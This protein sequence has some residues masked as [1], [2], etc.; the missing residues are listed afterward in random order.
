ML[1]KLVIAI[2]GPAA[3]GKSTTSKLVAER[4][5][6][7]YIDTGA[8]YRA[9]TWK[10][11]RN[12]IDLEE[13]DII[14]ELAERTSVRLE[15]A[16]DEIKVFLDGEDVSKEIRTQEVT[17]AVSAV[18]AIEKVRTVMVREQRKIGECGGVVVD[19]RDIGTVVFPNADVKIFMIADVEERARRRQ[20]ELER[21]GATVDLSKL[22]E[23]IVTRDKKDSGRNISPLRK[24]DDAIALD[25]TDLTIDEQVDFIVKKVFERL[26]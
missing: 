20:K 5:G 25:T 22:V 3:S 10:V 4:L 1:K 17:G 11:I 26:G 21:A 19:G 8:M 24:A 6:Y 14:G 16:N 12:K 13:T 15:K 9:I 23:E 7:L 2:D 18:S